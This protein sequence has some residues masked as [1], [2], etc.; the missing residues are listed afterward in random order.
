MRG[1]A[2]PEALWRLVDATVSVGADLDPR[3]VLQRVLDAAV[4][5]SDARYG[6]IGVLDAKGKGFVDLFTV[7]FTEEQIREIGVHPQGLGLLGHV[8]ETKQSVRVPVVADHPMS[9]GFPPNH[10]LMQSFLGVPIRVRDQ[11]FG[12]L[13]LADKQS[14]EVFTDVDEELVGKLATAAGI[15]IEHAR[16]FETVAHRERV[17][18][19]FNGV[20]T[21]LLAGLQRDDVLQIVATSARDLLGGALSSIV[22]P[23]ADGFAYVPAADGR[24]AEAY[25][26]RKIPGAIAK[27][28][29]RTHSSG[30][31][32]SLTAHPDFGYMMDGLGPALFVPINLDGPFGCIVVCRVIG[33]QPFADADL[34][35]LEALAGQASVVL[36]H[37]RRRAREGELVRA[38][39]HFRIAEHLQDSALQEIFSASLLLSGAVGITDAQEVRDRIGE[40]I[41]GLDRAITLTRRAIFDLTPNP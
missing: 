18:R 7:G 20:S 14:G 34:E 6:A 8:I 39:D 5:L 16:L 36:E 4:D 32:D 21:A 22:I 38:E 3:I 9:V 35:L 25:R 19:V 12:N 2:G 13:Y 31:F 1:A 17:I 27:R 11:V 37:D 41:A 33:E 30:T 15:A 29:L 24:L 28:L 10:P 23:D 40:A 26:G